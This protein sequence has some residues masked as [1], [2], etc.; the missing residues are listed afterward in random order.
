MLKSVS[1]ITN[2][3]GAL[4]YKGVWDAAANSPALASSAGTKGD[5]YV[6][7]VAGTTALNGISNWGVGDWAVFNGS[8]WQRVEGGA[9]LNGV[10]L[11]VTGNSDLG[12][13]R[14]AANTI[15]STNTNGNI[16]LTPNGTGEVDITK[17]DI[18]GG[19]IDGTIIGANSRAA[20]SFSSVT[21]TGKVV[22]DNAG[23][24]AGTTDI[25]LGALSGGAFLN[26]PA[27]TVG[28]L[29]VGGNAA[30]SF[31]GSQVATI[32]GSVG[33]PALSTFSDTNTGLYYPGADQIALS[34]GGAAK[35]FASTTGVGLST[36]TPNAPL[37]MASSYKQD[38]SAG[39]SF[40]VYIP[41]TS[42]MFKQADA[43]TLANAGDNG[44]AELALA[45]GT[46]IVL[47]AIGSVGVFTQS[48]DSRVTSLATI[49]PTGYV[50]AARV[51]VVGDAN[52]V[53]DGSPLYILA[54][55]SVNNGGTWYDF[56]LATGYRHQFYNARW[57]MVG[58]W[59][60]LSTDYNDT[61]GGLCKF[62]VRAASTYGLVYT[63][64][65]V[66][67]AYVKI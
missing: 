53:S 37:S 21:S 18:D 57:L 24:A 16:A 59:M 41:I 54:R 47:G 17:V 1:S 39:S 40:D 7:S 67:I 56:D 9:D 30:L 51:V 33:A 22:I 46:D 6:V 44:N 63:N 14:I 42:I 58:K 31:A 13:V 64:I 5:Y 38:G 4:N 10:N 50:V 52:V 61:T 27:A 25:S 65:S 8:A 48:N 43:S 23:S 32:T 19:A 55:S 28:Y 49:A 35:V 29:A 12:N 36:V 45:A 20:G 62:G 66:Q 3:L 11:T 26:T 2:A 60:P 34:A 15:S